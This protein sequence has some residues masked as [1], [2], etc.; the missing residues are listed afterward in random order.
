MDVDVPCPFCDAVDLGKSENW[1][2]LFG[3]ES[4]EV[5]RRGHA[6]SLLLD[7]APLTEG[8]LLLVPHRHVPSTAR[9]DHAEATEFR[10]MTIQAVQL[11]ADAYTQPTLFEH[12]A[13]SFTHHAGA[14]IEHAHLHLVPGGLH[15]G[16]RVAADFPDMERFDDL[17]TAIEEFRDSAYLLVADLDGVHGVRAE[18]CAT[19]YLRRLTAIALEDPRRWNWRDCIRHADHYGIKEELRSAASR[20]RA[21]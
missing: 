13:R 21:R 12:G 18:H 20:L 15:L 2:T 19:Q 4:G 1:T 7:T 8:H 10:T 17:T 16:R 9:L 3:E 6:V 14:C 5:L 11:L